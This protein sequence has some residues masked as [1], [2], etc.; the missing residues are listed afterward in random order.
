MKNIFSRQL[1]ENEEDKK[2]RANVF[3]PAP[4]NPNEGI[5][6][7]QSLSEILTAMKKASEENIFRVP[8]DNAPNY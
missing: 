8:R 1:E 6:P 7:G 2:A 5:R 4:A 3:G